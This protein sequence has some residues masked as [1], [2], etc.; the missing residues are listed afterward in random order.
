M[1]KIFSYR[2]LQ[3]KSICWSLLGILLP[4]SGA[5]TAY[6]NLRLRKHLGQGQAAL[7]PDA[8]TKA[9]EDVLEEDPVCHRLVPSK[10]ALTL[11]RPEGIRYF[12]SESC[13]RIF[14]Q[15]EKEQA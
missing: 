2:F 11:N 7:Q 12:C 9:I 10:Q 5:M 3:R 6:A 8:K 15:P 14:L 13:R 1:K 4:V